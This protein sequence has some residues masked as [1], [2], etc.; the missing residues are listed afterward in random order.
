MENTQ[1]LIE[2]LQHIA[3]FSANTFDA[4]APADP[5]PAMLPGSESDAAR[6]LIVDNNDISRRMLKGFLKPVSDVIRECS[7]ADE[8]MEILQSEPIDLVIL[9]LILPGVSG[10][11][12]CRWLK[13][14]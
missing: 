7:R 9:D 11:D 14:N 8:A 2:S 4:P 1:V 5:P 12:L 13:S 6:V 10:F 3:G